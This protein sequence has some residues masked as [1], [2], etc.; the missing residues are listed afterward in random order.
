[1]DKD[2][3]L[4][5]PSFPVQKLKAAILRLQVT[6]GNTSVP[7]TKTLSNETNQGVSTAPLSSPKM[8]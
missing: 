6:Q 7:T 5:R 1:M 4:I 3:S 2:K 8:L